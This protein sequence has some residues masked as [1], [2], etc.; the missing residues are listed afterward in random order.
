[1][2]KLQTKY[3]RFYRRAYFC[4]RLRVKSYRRT[5]FTDVASEIL[6]T[7]PAILHA[8]KKYRCGECD[9]TCACVNKYRR[10]RKQ[11]VNLVIL[12]THAK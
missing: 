8:R 3:K 7:L 6:C 12:Q 1:M 11:S 10:A 9:W 5:F 4:Y 2:L